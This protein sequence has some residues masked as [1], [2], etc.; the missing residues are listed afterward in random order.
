[1]PPGQRLSPLRE[2]VEWRTRVDD[3]ILTEEEKNSIQ[4]SQC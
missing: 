4:V 3:S 2:T 1:M